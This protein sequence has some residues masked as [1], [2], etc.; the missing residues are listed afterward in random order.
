M[1]ASPERTDFDVKVG[2]A[3]LLGAIIFVLVA[4][5]VS[6]L[7]FEV[8]GAE[9][10]KSRPPEPPVEIVGP[11]LQV[12]PAAELAAHR[13]AEQAKLHGYGWADRKANVVRIPIERAMELFVREQKQEDTP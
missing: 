11:R 4:L 2:W 6:G 3:F 8:F 5:V 7:V 10:E 13:H 9:N 1:S 12:D